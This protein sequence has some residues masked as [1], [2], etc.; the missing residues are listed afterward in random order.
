[1]KK[2][3]SVVLL[4][5]VGHAINDAQLLHLSTSPA[6]LRHSFVLNGNKLPTIPHFDIFEKTAALWLT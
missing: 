1:L 6:T 3:R 2:R 4:E 5:A